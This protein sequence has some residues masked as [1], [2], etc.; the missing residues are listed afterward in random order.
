MAVLFPVVWLLL[1]VH[2]HVSNEKNSVN[3]LYFV[4]IPATQ[5][6]H[7]PRRA[8]R[9]PPQN[10]I[11]PMTLYLRARQVATVTTTRARVPTHLQLTVPPHLHWVCY[12]LGMVLCRRVWC[13]VCCL[14]MGVAY[15]LLTISTHAHRNAIRFHL[16]TVHTSTRYVAANISGMINTYI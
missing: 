13:V 9:A 15:H 1:V 6:L 4:Q 8:Q 11:M 12:P 16:K 14:Q 5:V 3:W 10:Q 2:I 7:L